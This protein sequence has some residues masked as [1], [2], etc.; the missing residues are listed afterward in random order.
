MNCEIN[1]SAP[2][3]IRIFASE[4]RSGRVVDDSVEKTHWLQIY[5][6]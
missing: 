3:V 5:I 2:N 1:N 4:I 6:C